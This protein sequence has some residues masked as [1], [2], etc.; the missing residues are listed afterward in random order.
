METLEGLRRRL[1][2]L[3]GL[4]PLVRMMKALA[5]GS[6]HRDALA[7]RA[8]YVCDR[9]VERRLRAAPCE[10]AIG[11]RAAASLE[12]N[13]VSP[14][15]LYPVPGS[16]VASTAG[17]RRIPLLM[18]RGVPAVSREVLLGALV[19]QCF[20]VTI[21]RACAESLASENAAWRTAMQA[22]ERDQTGCGAEAAGALRRSGQGY[23]TAELLDAAT[24]LE[25]TQAG[26][27]RDTRRG[28]EPARGL[29]GV[30]STTRQLE[31]PKKRDGG[32]I[33]ERG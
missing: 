7:V 29:I 21:F 28:I 12:D 30:I 9:T 19:R 8:P 10:F 16:T 32:S 14:H 22:A 13:S 3:E 15:I 18:D 5:A 1:D 27:K 4:G 20:L 6:L 11:S 25:A 2:A 24:G 26:T 33:E 23:I 17:V 31:Y